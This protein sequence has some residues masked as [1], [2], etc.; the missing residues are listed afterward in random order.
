MHTKEVSE[1]WLEDEGEFVWIFLPI[2][3]RA[4]TNQFSNHSKQSFGV[5]RSIIWKVGEVLSLGNWLKG[6][7]VTAIYI[8]GLRFEKAVSGVV[9]TV[10]NLAYCE[11]G[12]FEFKETIEDIEYIPL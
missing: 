9:V 2:T 8:R 5:V 7:E 1:D 12:W 11:L 3:I 4:G 6:S 10:R